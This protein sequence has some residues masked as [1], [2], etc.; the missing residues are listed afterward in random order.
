MQEGRV[1]A[2]HLRDVQTWEALDNR[3][4]SLGFRR[5]LREAI[6]PRDLTA[7]A[8]AHLA[9]LQQLASSL[10]RFE[11]YRTLNPRAA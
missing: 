11:H 6:L 7:Y 3:M 10:M 1:T 8:R 9:A 5:L 2:R 4:R